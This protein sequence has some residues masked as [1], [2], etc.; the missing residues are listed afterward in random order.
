MTSLLLLTHEGSSLPVMPT[1]AP[2]I[3]PPGS[4]VSE[5]VGTKSIYGKGAFAMATDLTGYYL[6]AV[7]KVYSITLGTG[8][9]AFATLMKAY[10]WDAPSLEAWVAVEQPH[11]PCEIVAEV[12]KV[13]AL[14]M[15]QLARVLRVERAT[16]Y[17]WTTLEVWAKIREQAKKQR[18]RTLMNLVGQWS[19]LTPLPASALDLPLADGSTVLDLLCAE[20]LD[21]D[22]ILAAHTELSMR[23]SD[24]KAH[25]RARTLAFGEAIAASMRSMGQSKEPD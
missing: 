22:A 18:L 3:A 2:L 20:T 6:Q 9:G 4:G 8:L 25:R 15:A 13:F 21:V 19:A 17:S 12:R 11:L 5:Y 23:S 1:S 24:V 10:E 7:S 16:A 14:N